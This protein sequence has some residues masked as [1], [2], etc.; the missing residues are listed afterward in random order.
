MNIK[1][2]TIKIPSLHRFDIGN[3]KELKQTI[4]Q[5]GLIHP[6]V[7]RESPEDSQYL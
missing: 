7:V 5:H 6:I 4:H 2:N 3:L 1:L